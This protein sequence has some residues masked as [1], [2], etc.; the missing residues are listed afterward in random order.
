MRQNLR[1]V[2]AQLNLRVGDVQG[3][4]ERIIEA[5][6]SAREAWEADVIV[7]PE[8]ALCGYPPEDLLLRS[9]MQRRIESGLQRLRDEVRG[10]YLVLGYPWLEDELRYN[11]CAVIADGQLLATYY[12]QHLPNY[13][14]F[15][16]KRYFEPGRQPCVVDIKGVPVALSICEDIWHPEPMAQ[17]RAAGARL[18]LS[19]NA[20]PFHLDKQLEREEILAERVAE[21][22]MPVI[23]VNQVGGQDELVFDGGSCVMDAGGM[24]CQRA[25]AFV[26]GLYPVDLQVEDG[27]W[28]PRR[29][30]C[31]ELPELEASVYQAL[32]VGVRDYVRKNGF[33]GVL[34]G[35][36]GGIDSALTLA[37]AADALGAERVEAVMM[38]YHYTAQIS[39]EDA[40]AEARLLGV[41][42]RV[43]SIGPMVEAFQQVLAPVFDG[44]PRDASE[45][46]L[47]ARC[48]GTLLM[49]MSNKKG[50]LV[51]TTGNKSE[52]AVGYATLYGDMAGGFDVLKDVPKTLVFRLAEY[53]NSLGPVIPPRV[54]ERPPSAELAPGQRDEDSLP[55]YGV[56]DEILTLYI[57][58][59]LSANAI[60]AEGFDED[61]VNRVL[62]MVDR[63]EYKRR[64]A[65]VGVR[66]TQR[67]FGR[68]RR[69]PITSGWR[70]GD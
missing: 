45:E 13:R 41:A 11:A 3:N 8:L 15:D 68:D 56:L 21:G 36:S 55:P 5:A 48:R 32:V 26:E 57:E 63:N 53:R 27:C 25:P 49:A 30:H 35:L 12:K 60:I 28:V 61:T 42:Y 24:I 9:S 51:L 64:Q 39:L 10:I 18:M 54:I 34:L 31:V 29:T 43:M 69:Y 65:A 40:E 4:A 2:M 20:S 67:G 6:N 44:Q 33:N 50:S 58:H 23:Y 46:N 17:A 47:Q 7:F 16:E 37:V 59:D 22:G 38:P 52:L 1:I 62:A 14:V 19:L 66:V 70:L